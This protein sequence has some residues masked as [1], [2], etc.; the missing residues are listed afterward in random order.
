MDSEYSVADRRQ[1]AMDAQ[2]GT[3]QTDLENLS[4]KMTEIETNMEK[5]MDEMKSAQAAKLDE[6]KELLLR[7]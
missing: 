5:K 3:M 2:I 6:I 7:R 4:A 1:R